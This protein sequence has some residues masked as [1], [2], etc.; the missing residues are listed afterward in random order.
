MTSSSSEPTD[1][2]MLPVYRLA[3]APEPSLEHLHDLAT[4]LFGIENY[5]LHET[6]GRRLLRSTTQLIEVDNE[7]GAVWA[8]DRAELWNPKAK[9]QL[10]NVERAQE[11]TI[12]LVIL[13]FLKAQLA[14]KALLPNSKLQ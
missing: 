11:I 6:N 14:L 9:P 4:R 13:I 1:R 12:P 5:S 2:K 3:I 8:A 10:P 7:R